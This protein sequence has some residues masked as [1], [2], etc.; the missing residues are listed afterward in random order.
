MQKDGEYTDFK[1][2]EKLLFLI[3]YLKTNKSKAEKLENVNCVVQMVDLEVATDVR[4]VA[5][6]PAKAERHATDEP[7]RT[8][9]R[10][11]RSLSQT[12]QQA[13]HS[14]APLGRGHLNSSSLLLSRIFTH[15]PI[16]TFRFWLHFLIAMI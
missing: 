9:R 11:G 12:E 13:A 6:L 3:K 10:C 16:F 15:S 1:K 7:R 5:P 2:C 4:Q 14:A 8:D